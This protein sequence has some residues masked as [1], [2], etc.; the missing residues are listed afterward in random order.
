MLF[1]KVK[2]LVQFRSHCANQKPWFSNQK[3]LC[4][5]LPSLP[6]CEITIVCCEGKIEQ[7]MVCQ[8]KTAYKTNQELKEVHKPTALIPITKLESTNLLN[9]FTPVGFQDFRL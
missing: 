1:E 7:T 2:G 3:N 4:V 8:L 5:H 9:K 6:P